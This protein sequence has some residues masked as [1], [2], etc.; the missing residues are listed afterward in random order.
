[1]NYRHVYMR[2]IM[3]AKSEEKSGLR[4]K[5]NGEYYERHHILPNSLFHLWRTKKSNLVLLTLKEHIFCHKLLTKIWPS[6]EMYSALWMLSVTRKGEKI[7]SLKEYE[8]LKQIHAEKMSKMFK[9]NPEKYSK[10]RFKKGMKTWNKGLKM[11]DDF[12]KKVSE[13]TKQ[14]MKNIDAA[15]LR[16]KVTEGLT[17]EEVLEY[18]KRYTPKNPASGNKNAMANPL[19]K[20][21]AAAKRREASEL[22]KKYKEA[23]GRL[24]WNEWNKQRKQMLI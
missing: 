17:D 18:N 14:A 3:H 4:K 2:I 12:K 7:L 15:S 13:C 10:T 19:F 11:A 24:L 8:K 21:K 1:M 23:G 9:E 22:Y 16:R 20:E 6:K 5:G